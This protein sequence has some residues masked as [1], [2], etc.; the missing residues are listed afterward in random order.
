MSAKVSKPSDSSQARYRELCRAT[1]VPLHF[2]P[3]WLDAVC[4]GPGRWNVSLATDRGGQIT[5]VLPYSLTRRLGLAAVVLPPFTSYAGPWYF[6]PQNPEFKAVSRLAFEKS[7][8]AELIRQLPRHVF[9]RQNFRPEIANW[10][11]FHWAG[12]RQTT[13]YTY[14]LD[15]S[16]GTQTLQENWENTLRTDLKKARAATRIVVSEPS[17]TLPTDRTDRDL[18][19][20]LYQ[21]SR[22][23]QGLPPSRHRTAFQRLYAAL[24]ER[25][26]AF[27]AIARDRHT[28]APHAGIFLAHDQRQAALLFTGMDPAHKA[29]GAVLGLLESALYF[30]LERGLI[31]DFEGSMHPNVERVFRAFGGRLTPYAR[32]W[33]WF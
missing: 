18:L 26:A 31:L 32:V 8:G 24:G 22:R 13:R 9:F 14:V 1:W 17:G 21:K 11:P 7:V 19:F 15:S 29:S 30:C 28:D 12:F 3:W 25:G 27:A 33:R 6:Y 10:L 4:G 23:R 16:V 20:D 5:G 2:Q